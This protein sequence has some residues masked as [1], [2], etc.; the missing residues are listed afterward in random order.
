MASWDGVHVGRARIGTVTSATRS[1]LLNRTTALASLDVACAALGTAVEI[2]KLRGHSRRLPAR[3][4]PF[5]HFDPQKTRV[6]ATPTPEDL[7]RTPATA[8]VS[9]LE[10][11]GSDVRA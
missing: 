5:P 7:A 1:P 8:A 3:M 9:S 4:V 2:G 6:R 11:R 10:P